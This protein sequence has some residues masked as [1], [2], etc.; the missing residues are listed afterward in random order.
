[1]LRTLQIVSSLKKNG[2]ETFIMNVFRNIDKSKYNIDFLIF[3]ETKDGFYHEVI[4]AGANVY[5]LPSRKKGFF[6][7]H[8]NL[9]EFFKHKGSNY[10]AVH[11]H[12]TSLTTI[13][14]LIYSKKSG[15]KN[16]IMHIH[17]SGYRGMHNLIFHKINKLR[18]GK[19]A[20]KFLACSRKAAYWG[21]G[22][23]SLFPVSIIPNGINIERFKFDIEKRKLKRKE[24]GLNKDDYVAI[25]VG[26]FH[27]VKNHK[28]LFN[29][30]EEIKALGV[31]IK[32]LCVGEGVLFDAFNKEIKERKL[33]KEI[34]LLGY[35]EDISELLSAS[36]IFIFPSFR[37]GF[38]IAALEAQANGLN[39]LASTKVP[40]EV[41]LSDK[42]SFLDLKE[43]P[44]VWAKK[45]LEIKDKCQH[46]NVP[47]SINRYSSE[48][49]LKILTKV[50]SDKK[51]N[52]S[53]KLFILLN[54]DKYFISHR[55]EIAELA[56]KKDWKV[57]VVSK[58]TGKRSI[59][60]S[61]GFDF[62]NLP[63]KPT[64]T[65]LFQEVKLLR[66]IFNLLKK[67][68]GGVFLIVGI[69]NIL[70]SSLASQIA[71]KDK[72]IFGVSGL[73][74]LF[75]ENRNRLINTIIINLLRKGLKGK[76]KK[77]IFQN[78]DDEN[79]FLTK[80]I[81]RREQVVFIKGSGVDLKKYPP[82]KKTYTSNKVRIIFTGRM[83]REK[84]IDDLIKAAELL[85]KNYEDKIEFI[86]CGEITEN[87]DSFTREELLKK[88][89]DK[90]IKWLGYREDIP[91]L[92]MSSDIMCFP[93][94]YREGVPK[95]LLEASAAG[96]P[97]ITT[98]SV[99][100]RDVV[101]EGIN[102]FIVPI[103]SPHEIASAIKKLIID[104]KL[105]ENMGIKSREM[106]EKDY[107]VQDVAKLHLKLFN[108]ILSE[109]A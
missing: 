77:I 34:K 11:M 61:S 24:L 78:H 74:T 26:M 56:Q 40:D 8:N 28:F 19:M 14:P 83:L 38:G 92:L 85:R 76:K 27:P 109:K 73:G 32:L 3:D 46:F 50:Y 62:I 70:W 84:G 53:K 93:S 72:L 98:N 42:F 58:D 36:D 2:T 51:E 9:K 47:E 99:G 95:S 64:G 21:Y 43:G 87:R 59:I 29:V 103:H 33:G 17:G 82:H 16:R 10:D 90:Y 91:D 79:L 23:N 44:K 105:R 18:I 1:M 94:Y 57:T 54:D 75:G 88:T 6:N 108:Q 20:N 31:N 102:G 4:E 104:K 7:Y 86:L 66:F 12:A 37:E 49:T 30:I 22:R 69:K 100:C 63:T 89:D 65:N 68:R 35:R 25:H 15:I 107:N 5:I 52:V 101:V 97:I 13:A 80:N 67:N 106:A 96:L 60:E 39:V 81:C 41:K 55:F 71:N 48:N 45:I